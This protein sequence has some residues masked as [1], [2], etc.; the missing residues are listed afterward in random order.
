MTT[1]SVLL[2]RTSD[3][4]PTLVTK[5]AAGIRPSLPDKSA[6]WC[7]CGNRSHTRDTAC[8]R[9]QLQRREQ[10]A[11]AQAHLAGPLRARDGH[12]E[13]VAVGADGMRLTCVGAEHADRGVAPGA[14]RVGPGHVAV[15]AHE[16][17]RAL[18]DTADRLHRPTSP[19][20]TGM[21]VARSASASGSA[22]LVAVV[23][24]AWASA[25]MASA[26]ASRRPGSSSDRTSSSRNTG[27]SPM[28]AASHAASA[29]FSESTAL[30]CSPREANEGRPPSLAVALLPQQDLVRG[31]ALRHGRALHLTAV[32]EI[33]ARGRREA[34]RRR[35]ERLDQL[36][37]E[38][39]A[40]QRDARRE[41]HQLAVPEGQLVLGQ[42]YLFARGPQQRI[43]L[44]NDPLE[45]A[46]LA[47]VRTVDLGEH[48]VEIAPA[49]ARRGTQELDVLREE[50]H[51]D[52]LT[53][54]VI[55]PLPRAVEEMTAWSPALA[56]RRREEQQLHAT[57]AFSPI[58]VHPYSAHVDSPAHELGVVVRARRIAARGEVDRLEEVRLA[59]AVRTDEGGDAAR[60]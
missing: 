25:G 58:D 8:R 59:C 1:T 51:D 44:L 48:R 54:H 40:P 46:R 23:S 33:E 39:G 37:H 3:V 9:A 19:R 7:G 57:V 45:L 6:R 56:F 32:R 13:G 18:D 28:R 38:Q 52:E 31:A 5:E 12:H 43:A 17:Q 24:S 2:A 34:R 16:A 10:L 21:T 11:L 35:A 53:R 36:G 42:D 29:I 49:R 50:R 26:R 20:R 15:D 27:G 41:P 4:L 55:G 22:V 60:Q 30:R 14:H 47:A